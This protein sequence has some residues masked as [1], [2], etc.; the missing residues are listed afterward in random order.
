MAIWWRAGD[1]L[2]KSLLWLLPF[3]PFRRPSV[4]T[5]STRENSLVE[6]AKEFYSGAVSCS[7]FRDVSR[8]Q[9]IMKA[10]M[11]YDEV[12]RLRFDP[13]WSRVFVRISPRVAPSG[14]VRM[15]AAQKSTTCE[16]FV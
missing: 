10:A 15:K 16:I 12:K 9:A 4:A 7:D 8:M 1:D 14:R 2:V 6:I 5:N 11:T 13:P 3:V